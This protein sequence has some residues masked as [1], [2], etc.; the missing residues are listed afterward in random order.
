MEGLRRDR[1]SAAKLPMTS[2][3]SFLIIKK[4]QFV[5][6]QLLIQFNPSSSFTRSTSA[7]R[8]TSIHL[9]SCTK[10]KCTV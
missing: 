3:I 8:L 1:L 4:K 6:A 2:A 9:I 10:D 7:C 5:S